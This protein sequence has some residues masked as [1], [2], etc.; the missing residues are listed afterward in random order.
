MRR[1][2]PDEEGW[3]G[4][5]DIEEQ[6]CRRRKPQVLFLRWE[7]SGWLLPSSHSHRVCI[8]GP[9]FCFQLFLSGFGAEPRSYMISCSCSAV[10]HVT[11][12]ACIPALRV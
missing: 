12:D 11:T 5:G 8:V 10:C 9:H 6:S 3:E 2:S 1:R 7:I 4:L